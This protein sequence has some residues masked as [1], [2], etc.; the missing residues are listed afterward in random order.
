VLVQMLENR[1]HRVLSAGSLAEARACAAIARVDVL[2]SDIGLPDG[3]GYDLM[4]ELS[5]H[6]PLQGIALTGYGMEDDVSE[7]RAAGFATHLTKPVRIRMIDE[8]LAKIRKEP[9]V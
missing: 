8:A 6:Y 7:S 3:S 5:A 2:I 1:G 4:A 9:G